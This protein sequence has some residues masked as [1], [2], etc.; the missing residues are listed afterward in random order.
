MGFPVWSARDPATYGE[1]AAP[2]GIDYDICS[3]LAPPMWTILVDWLREVSLEFRLSTRAFQTAVSYLHCFLACTP[4]TKAAFQCLGIACLQL[5][6]QHIDP[7]TDFTVAQASEICAGGASEV[8]IEAFQA[9]LRRA[10]AIRTPRPILSEFLPA[11]SERSSPALENLR[12]LFCDA[13]MTDSRLSAILDKA[14]LGA[15]IHDL[16]LC[17]SA[18]LPNPA[19]EA[20]LVATS[21][22]TNSRDTVFTAERA[23]KSY[24]LKRRLYQVVRKTARSNLY[25]RSLHRDAILAVERALLNEFEGGV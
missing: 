3:D 7:G 23:G 9:S 22:S 21:S 6:V 15:A 25:I 5:A 24:Y 12:T 11:L 10:F 16:S 8:D 17:L 18:S 20:P 2:V 4:V 19:D 1:S 13:A 14:A